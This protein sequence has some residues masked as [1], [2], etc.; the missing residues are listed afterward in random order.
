MWNSKLLEWGHQVEWSLGDIARGNIESDSFSPLLQPLRG[1]L[2]PSWHILSSWP[3]CRKQANDWSAAC[4]WGRLFSCGLLS[5]SLSSTCTSLNGPACSYFSSSLTLTGVLTCLRALRHTFGWLLLCCLL[6][7]FVQ[8]SLTGLTIAQEE[9][10]DSMVL[11]RSLR[12]Q[13]VNSHWNLLHSPYSSLSIFSPGCKSPC[14]HSTAL[15]HVFW[16]TSSYTF[17]FGLSSLLMW[18]Q[19]IKQ[20][21]LLSL[22]DTARWHDCLRWA[23]MRVCTE[24]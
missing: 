8:S 7:F 17:R 21:G 24:I 4:L 18:Q 22:G 12:G 15:W 16:L 14:H 2:W 19:D 13:K 3:V 6:F 20:P 10:K 23:L 5:F 1:C 11:L 9:A